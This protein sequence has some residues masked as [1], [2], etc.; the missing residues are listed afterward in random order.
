MAGPDRWADGVDNLF[1]SEQVPIQ[2]TVKLAIRAHGLHG[3]V[4][5]V[6]RLQ[7]LLDTRLAPTSSSAVPANRIHYLLPLSYFNRHNATSARDRRSL[8]CQVVS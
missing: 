8:A 6:G 3:A 7:N 4:V 1:L 5:P 2:W